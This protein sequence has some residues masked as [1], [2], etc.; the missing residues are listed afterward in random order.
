MTWNNYRMSLSIGADRRRP[1]EVISYMEDNDLIFLQL[2]TYHEHPVAVRVCAQLLHAGNSLKTL[3][4]PA[5][6]KDHIH[7]QT[8]ADLK[9]A[10]ENERQLEAQG[11]QKR[12]DALTSM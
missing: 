6:G 7:L 11:A 1:R 5:L 4:G 9:R 3:S 8:V 2:A 10:R 12:R